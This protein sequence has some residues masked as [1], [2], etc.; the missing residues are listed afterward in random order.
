MLTLSYSACYDPYNTVFRLLSIL[1]STPEERM[2]DETIRIADFFLCFPMRL[3]ELRPPNAVP[4][5]R[6]RKNAAIR[7]A[8]FSEYELLPSSKV[9][10]ERMEVIQETAMSALS[11][12]SMVLV[13][14]ETGGGMRMISLMAD[15]LSRKLIEETDRFI[16]SQ[17]S[18]IDLVSKDLPL[19]EVNGP[20]GIK[21]RTGLGEWQYDTI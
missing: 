3:K 5:M 1:R 2:F 18:L 11:A 12:K 13:E 21:A 8:S 7:E 19:M 10:F 20:D 6:R 15:S 4:G 17:R 16:S 14:K 9:L